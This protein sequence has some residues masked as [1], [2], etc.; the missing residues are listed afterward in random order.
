[1]KNS[2]QL[3]VLIN[4]IGLLCMLV[5]LSLR[6]EAL[7]DS[8][9]A[10]QTL[11]AKL[12]TQ[13][14]GIITDRWYYSTEICVANMQLLLKLAFIFFSDYK[15]AR[16]FA[17]LIYMLLI[18]ASFLFMMKAAGLFKAGLLASAFLLFP[19]NEQ[20]V[21]YMVVY[22]GYGVY[23]FFSFLIMGTLFLLLDNVGFQDKGLLPVFKEKG[24]KFKTLALAF[25]GA[26]LC[27]IVSLNGFRQ[28]MILNAPLFVT[29]LILIIYDLYRHWKED[30]VLSLCFG[31]GLFITVISVVY[32]VASL[33]GVLTSR[34]L[35]A[36]YFSSSKVYQ[37]NSFQFYNLYNCVIDIANYFGWTGKQNIFSF[38]G[39]VDLLS[40]LML[41]F[42]IYAIIK[43]V[44]GFEERS[45]SEKV[46]LIYTL[47]TMVILLFLYSM[48]NMYSARYWLVIMQFVYTIPCIILA[49][50]EDKRSSAIYL[51][52]I[53]LIM[54]ISL[55]Q[56][57]ASEIG[58]EKSAYVEAEKWLT[59]NGYKQG[60]ANYWQSN[61]FAELSS[62]ALE[63][64]TMSE[65][66]EGSVD[67]LY[68]L[69]S[70]ER[71]L[72]DK[73]HTTELPKGEFFVMLTKQYFHFDD[74]DEA[75]LLSL[76]QYLV[77]DNEYVKIYA[78]KDME[79]YKTAM[80]SIQ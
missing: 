66:V 45:D 41:I 55:S 78:F 74:K 36:E 67:R 29:G 23:I 51:G 6:Y 20:Y 53:C 47:S 8:D 22:L 13:T 25:A 39:L 9:A 32:A 63:M 11:L 43:M 5:F 58:K 56:F 33:C 2:K 40:L 52:I 49:E 30:G 14:G 44:T 68:E 1:M 17:T 72:Q 27:F 38:F 28:L 35:L 54:L 10:A 77:Y 76:P 75:K 57:K 71:W 48:I 60:Y 7:I 37:W 16:L 65:D 4:C 79:E 12:L 80:A 73:K 24:A 21:E 50:R 26:A 64:Y 70:T 19:F 62:G 3:S 46:L 34:V 61:L 69:Q 18:I 59:D 15:Q 31:K 42:T